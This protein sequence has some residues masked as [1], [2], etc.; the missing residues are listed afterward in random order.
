[1]RM[2]L[3][4]IGCLGLTVLFAACITVNIYFPA[5]EVRAAAEEIV[6]ETWGG[7]AQGPAQTEPAQGPQGWLWRALPSPGVAW[8]GEA[9]PN[10]EV[11][12]AAIR[13]LKAAMKARAA[14]LKPALARGNVGIAKDGMLA[15][16][17]VAGLNLRDQAMLRR[18]I[19]AENRDR[20][21]L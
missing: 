5:P 3:S 1:M 7:P 15:I 18:L 14:E 10:I 16:K 9:S 4:A 6:E 12:T 19:D 8:A 11:S 2:T 21:S 13:K 17:D 20:R